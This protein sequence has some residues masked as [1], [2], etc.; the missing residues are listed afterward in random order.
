[1]P[2]NLPTVGAETLED[3]VVRGDAPT[4]LLG[5]LGVELGIEGERYIDDAAAR[6]ADDM[7]MRLDRAIEAAAAW[8]LDGEDLPGIG[9]EVEVA[10]DRATADFVILCAH[11]VVDFVGGGMVVALA[12]GVKNQLSL[13]GIPSLHRHA[14]RLFSINGRR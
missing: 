8:C 4:D 11:D 1:M 6:G 12:H 3:G 14:P 5:R 7:R 9:Q 10:V 2:R 13:P